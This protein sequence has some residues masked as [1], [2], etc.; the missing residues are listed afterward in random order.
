[1]ARRATRKNQAALILLLL[2]LA[3]LAFLYLSRRNQPTT[4][5]GDSESA[6]SRTTPAAGTSGSPIAN[7]G[8]GGSLNGGWFQLYFTAP[9]YP[10]NPADHKG[11]LDAKL[12]ELMDTAQR[13]L[14]VADY[15]FDLANVADAMV[16][17]KQRGVTVR[18]VT[19]SDTLNN[20]KNKPVQDA[21]A[22]LK[23]AGIPV[24]GDNRQPIMHN[25]FTVVDQA[26][27][28]TGSWNY[29]DGD[30]YYLNNNMIVISSKELAANYTAEF[31]KMFEL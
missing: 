5:A 7:I 23:G 12:A 26:V 24:V 1:M 9:K 15:D 4:G 31:N 16:R 22:R 8:S 27:V 6:A 19:D 29:T 14:D 20:T 30:T 25:K 17:A 28:E 3:A 21:F 13:S 2:L 18:M 10:D 11:G